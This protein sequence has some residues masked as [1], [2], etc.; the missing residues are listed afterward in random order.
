MSNCSTKLMYKKLNTMNIKNTN[1]FDLD[2]INDFDSGNDFEKIIIN[3]NDEIK[4]I[5]EF[6]QNLDE[7]IF[8]GITGSGSCC[9]AAFD[10]YEIANNSLSLFKEAYPKLWSLVAENN[11]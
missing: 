5:L 9:F 8:C 3:E 11:C 7:T 2:E 1:E 6:L 4:K 10:N